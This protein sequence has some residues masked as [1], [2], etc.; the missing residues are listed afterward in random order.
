G[1]ISMPLIFWSPD[2]WTRTAPPPAEPSTTLFWSS[3]W[4]FASI[5]CAAAR[6][7]GPPPIPGAPG[8]AWRAPPARRRYRLRP[9]PFA[10]L[11]I[12]PNGN[13]AHGLCGFG[14]MAAAR[15]G[16]PGLLLVFEERDFQLHGPTEQDLCLLLDQRPAVGIDLLHVD[17]A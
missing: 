6:A 13:R 17:L 8:I 9:E 14:E 2:I 7:F 16:A 3:S 11:R 5:S 12:L 1:S 15:A 4:A 10:M